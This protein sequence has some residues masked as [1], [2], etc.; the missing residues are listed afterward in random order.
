MSRGAQ[1]L[2]V[3]LSR[4]VP[5]V[6]E[7]RRA[8]YS[9]EKVSDALSDTLDIPL[10]KEALGRDAHEL[11][12]N[13]ARRRRSAPS[14]VYP[15]W[16][17]HRWDVL[18]LP[19]HTLDHIGLLHAGERIAAMTDAALGTGICRSARTTADSVEESAHLSRRGGVSCSICWKAFCDDAVRTTRATAL[20]GDRLPRRS[21]HA[22]RITRSAPRSS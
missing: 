7:T 15:S 21:S 4:H 6:Q 13:A 3:V 22:R 11:G 19:G 18:S 1:A 2:P 9:Q 14:Q 5:N 16:S 20:P 12:G 8:D 10:G 17:R